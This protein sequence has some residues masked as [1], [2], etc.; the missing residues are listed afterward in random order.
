MVY[1]EKK[2]QNAAISRF[3]S[4]AEVK[5]IGLWVPNSPC[6]PVLDAL[7]VFREGDLTRIFLYQMTIAKRH[8]IA[9]CVK[10]QLLTLM[11]NFGVKQFTLLFVVDK[12][13]TA[14]GFKK[15]DVVID[16]SV[17]LIQRV[18]VII[19]DTSFSEPVEFNEVTS[20]IVT[21]KRKNIEISSN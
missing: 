8:A 4:I 1:T 18:G 7:Y 16:D 13:S 17:Q 14:D 20:K 19:S 3:D 2:S 11:E 6:F 5:S 15:F 12:A 9:T 21:R 10:Q